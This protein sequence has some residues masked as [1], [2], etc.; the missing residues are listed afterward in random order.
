MASLRKPASRRALDRYVRQPLLRGAL[1][2]MRKPARM[3]GHSALHSFLER[4]FRA[5]HRMGGAAE[6]LSTIEARETAL[7]NRIVD[8]A[9]DPFPDPMNLLGLRK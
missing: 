9:H 8:G 2:M 7:M 5:F 4:G 1:A 6:F 3:P